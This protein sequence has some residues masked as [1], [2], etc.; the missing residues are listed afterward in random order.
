MTEQRSP[1]PLGDFIRSHRERLTPEQAGL[2]SGS[3]RRAKGL[4]REEVA[5]LCGISPTWLTWIEQGRTQSVSATTLAALAAALQLT[6]AQTDYLFNLAGQKNPDEGLA[7]ANPEAEQMLAQATSQIAS[8]A[9]VLDAIWQIPAWNTQ[10]SEL[11]CGWL[12]QDGE[13]NLL[14]FMFSHPLAT[15]L[16]D[17]WPTRARRMVAEFRAETST[18]QDDAANVLV[19]Q[20]REQ[21]RAFDELWRQQDVQG[22]EG[23]ERVFNHTI[24]GRLS[25]QQLTLRLANAPG[26][27]LVM[28]I[29]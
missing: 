2:P 14:H 5:T 12:D 10:A 19:S 3:R 7:A 1:S 15:Q 20:L 16:V 26:L 4:R 24:Q 11:F 17:D 8:P 22:R 23:G 27:K 13:K 25:Y 21:S 18:R 28:L 29:R 9:Y 6:R